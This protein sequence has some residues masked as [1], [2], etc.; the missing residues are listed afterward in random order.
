IGEHASSSRPNCGNV[1]KR[2]AMGAEIR[3]YVGPLP[4]TEND[5]GRFFGRDDEAEHVVSLTV[6]HP[7]FLLYARSGAGKSSLIN[8]DVI[9]RLRRSGAEIIGP[10]RIGGA[11]PE[12]T[13]PHSIANIFTYN[14]LLKLNA[15][16]GPEAPETMRAYLCATGPDQA[17]TAP[18]VLIID[19]F[20][21]IF[22]SF[23]ERWRD[24]GTF[25]DDLGDALDHDRRLRVLLVMREEFLAGIEA[26]ATQ[27]PERARVRCRLEPLRRRA[28]MAAIQN[29]LATTGKRFAPGAAEKL[30]AELMQAPAEASSGYAGSE[31]EF[32]EPLHL[33][34]VCQN[35]WESLPAGSVE[36]TEDLI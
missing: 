28:A 29:P 23:P 31:A 33:Q 21:E 14:A 15:A 20:E 12:G 24:R 27:L 18:R 30:V 19:Q 8:A 34:V 26:Y 7:L 3:P 5:S 17:S 36:I 6:A 35:I 32:I 2:S 9:P 13:D 22:T 25:F 11:L 10:I 4:F 16:T 1:G